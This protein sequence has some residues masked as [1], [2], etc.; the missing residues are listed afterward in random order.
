MRIRMVVPQAV[1]TTMRHYEKEFQ[2]LTRERDS[3]L[4]TPSTLISPDGYSMRLIAP[5]TVY[6]SALMQQFS[7]QMPDVGQ[8]ESLVRSQLVNDALARLYIQNPQLVGQTQAQ[9]DNAGGL[10]PGMDSTMKSDIR[11]IDKI[12]TADLD[13]DLGEPTTLYTYKPNFWKFSGNG[14]LQ[15]T[16][17]YFSQNW[18]QGGES[19]Y[20]GTAMLTLQLNYDNKQHTQWENK[21][22]FQ[23]GFQTSPS[24]T[25][26]DLKPTSN[27]VRLT[28]KYGRKAVSTLYYTTQ[29]LTYTQLIPQYDNNSDNLRSNFLGPLYVNLSAGL[30]FKWN[31]KNRFSGDIYVAPGSY[32]LRYVKNTELA[33]RYGI[34]DGEHCLHDGGSSITINWNWTIW[35]NITY[36]SR[37]YF[38]SNYHYVNFEWEN[39]FNFTINKYLST[40]LFLYP[41]YDNSSTNYDKGSGYF[42]FR[43]WLSLGLN[44][45]W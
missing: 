8:D 40:K 37:M 45:N 6:S 34:P 10:R 33:S 36:Q 14:S 25:K 38:F 17:S 7:A 3:L 11:L 44:Y 43:E 13:A 35:K 28:S 5:T 26:H 2:R 31:V 20:A 18:Y 4:A 22:E 27:L 12:T 19:N 39:T 42:M 21:L 24:D 15:F 1:D 9:L 29:L 23:L 30:D 32:N 41:K 16:Q